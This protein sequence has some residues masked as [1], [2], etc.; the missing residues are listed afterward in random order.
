MTDSAKMLQ[1]YRAGK[2]PRC[3]D[4]ELIEALIEQGVLSG[5]GT[6]VPAVPL[7][8]PNLPPESLAKIKQRFADHYRGCTP[9]ILPKG[10]RVVPADSVH[11]VEAGWQFCPWSFTLG[12]VAVCAIIVLLAL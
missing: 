10:C 2:R 3:K 4:I 1:E 12:V 11:R 7:P 8:I 5:G 6:P 9:V